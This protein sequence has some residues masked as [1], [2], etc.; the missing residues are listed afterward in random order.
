M[1]LLKVTNV[2]VK[3]K[4]RNAPLSPLLKM[5]DTLLIERCSIYFIFLSRD[6][7][8]IKKILYQAKLIGFVYFIKYATQ[9]D[10]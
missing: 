2:R 3:T 8:M 10:F 1:Q 5:V 4:E 9:C 6:G 7:L